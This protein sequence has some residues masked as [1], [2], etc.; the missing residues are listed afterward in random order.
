[1]SRKKIE[2]CQIAG[3]PRNM[4]ADDLIERKM[5]V[6]TVAMTAIRDCQLRPRENGGPATEKC[7]NC[8][9]IN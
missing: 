5:P 8:P 7:R 4:S 9:F 6:S 1:M 2:K 3:E